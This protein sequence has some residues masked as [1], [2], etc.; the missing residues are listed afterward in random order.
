M[1][2]KTKLLALLLVIVML[3]CTSCDVVT[4]AGDYIKDIISS[5]TGDTPDVGGGGEG[6][7][8]EVTPPEEE[9][10]R[11]TVTF[12][13]NG[14]AAIDPLKVEDGKRLSNLPTPKKEGY[15]FLGWYTDKECT[16]KWN[17]ITKVSARL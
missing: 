17:N 3:F 7:G 12:V 6:G 16:K 8:G 1:K 2:L 11:H 9:D 15:K 5:I 4:Q 13:T 10:D 14:A